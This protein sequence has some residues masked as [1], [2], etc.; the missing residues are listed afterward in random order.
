MG[1]RSKGFSGAAD[2]NR[3]DGKL[4]RRF[5]RE[6]IPRISKGDHEMIGRRTVVGLSLLCA[7]LFSAVAASSASAAEETT[8]FTCVAEE[9]GNF[10]DN[11]CTESNPGAGS[12]SHQEIKVGETTEKVN[13]TQTENAV[14]KSI[15]GGLSAEIVCTGMSTKGHLKNEA[16]PPMKV[17]GDK[18]TITFTGCSLK[19][20]LATIEGCKVPAE[21]KTNEQTSETTKGSMEVTFK[22]TTGNVFATFLLS[23]CKEIPEKNLEVTGSAKAIPE[24]TTLKTTAASTEGKGKV[25]ENNGLWLSGQKATFVS[26]STVV[27]EGGSGIALTTN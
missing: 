24:G 3:W 21:I 22:P 8:A 17:K 20:T 2:P 1:R 25:S 19:G 13:G 6:A 9:K 18:I 16:G 26:K 4:A 11:H 10:N 27:M 23:A 14:L 15:V 5:G 7:L 12:F